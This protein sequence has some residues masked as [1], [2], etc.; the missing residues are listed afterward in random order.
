MWGGWGWGMRGGR[1]EKPA[2]RPAIGRG[3]LTGRLLGRGWAA[4]A[5]ATARPAEDGAHRSLGQYSLAYI[6]PSWAR[7]VWRRDARLCD[8]PMGQPWSQPAMSGPEIRR[9][10]DGVAIT[11]DE[12]ILVPCDEVIDAAYLNRCQQG[13][14]HGQIIHIPERL[15][16]GDVGLEDFGLDGQDVQQIVDLGRC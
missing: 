14:K 13:A 5:I 4:F 12:Q 9:R 2:W 8:N 1:K 15:F 16:V 6:T 11:E 7:K 10:Y 3:Y